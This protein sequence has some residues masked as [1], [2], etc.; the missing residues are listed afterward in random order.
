[1]RCRLSEEVATARRIFPGGWVSTFALQDFSWGWVSTFALHVCPD[2]CPAKCTNFS[3]T[4]TTTSTVSDPSN[5]GM[6]GLSLAIG[7]DGRP[8]V[9]YCEMVFNALK[10]ARCNNASCTSGAAISTVD[11]PSDDVGSPSAISVDGWPVIAYRNAT[12]GY[13]GHPRQSGNDSTSS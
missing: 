11:N 6:G 3:C 5:N 13:L 1:M 4:S 12:D 8:V 7:S 9:S 10:V 2:V